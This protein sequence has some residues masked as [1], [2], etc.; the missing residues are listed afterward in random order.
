MPTLATRRLRFLPRL[1]ALALPLAG[2][3][4][5]PTTASAQFGGGAAAYSERFYGQNFYD[6]QHRGLFGPHGGN[7]QFHNGIYGPGQMYS[8]QYVDEYGLARPRRFAPVP[9]TG[10]L[11]PDGYTT[12]YR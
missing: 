4:L 3:W 11:G 9:A 7:R 1:V 8:R 10:W 2:G 6:H 5:A 12:P